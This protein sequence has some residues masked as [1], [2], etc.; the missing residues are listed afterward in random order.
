MTAPPIPG[1]PQL[2]YGKRDPKNAPALPFARYS[3]V[4]AE[5]V[6]PAV[7]YLGQVDWAGTMNGNDAAGDC[8]ACMTANIAL[9]VS[10]VLTGTGLRATLD[11]VWAI[12]K[13][14]N[15]DFDPN[16]TAETNGPGSNSDGGMDIQTLLEDWTKT[17]FTI[18][19]QHVQ[20]IGF[21]KVDHANLA[22]IKAAISIGGVLATGVQ[23]AAAQQDQFPG[24]WD[25]VEGSPIEGG[26]AIIDGGHL[27]GS[28]SGAVDVKAACWAAEFGTTDEFLSKQMDEAWLPI[29]A[30]HLGSKEFIAGM[31]VATLA[32]DITAITGQPFPVAVNPDP[33]PVP[34]PTPVPVPDPVPP[35]P[36]DPPAPV[37]PAPDG[38]TIEELEDALVT[39]FDA[40]PEGWETKFH[41]GD[42]RKVAH[43]IR[44]LRES[45]D[46]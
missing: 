23:V 6:Y 20:L 5:P 15:P 7:D 37:P 39:F 8:V 45:L 2:K 24:T 3:S 32:A 9:L 43:A 1:A 28:G 40:L 33:A 36:V 17:G 41:E 30:W 46:S 26:H 12:Y 19:G 29:T 42:T 27:D 4:T 31:D 22:E 10:T 35:A 38:P 34:D 14:Q 18:A 16:G 25:Y 21:L 11:E 13:T 44:E